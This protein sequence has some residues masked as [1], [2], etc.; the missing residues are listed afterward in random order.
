MKG[1][2]VTMVYRSFYGDLET[3][4]VIECIFADGLDALNHMNQ[5]N[6]NRARILS[7]ETKVNEMFK[8][9]ETL[10]EEEQEEFYSLEAELMIEQEHSQYYLKDFI[11]Q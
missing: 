5:L 6:E 10:T 11:L 1:S 9:L 8:I 7:S 3:S 4:E 2:R